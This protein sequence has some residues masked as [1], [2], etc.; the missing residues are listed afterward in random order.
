MPKSLN[1]RA[2]LPRIQ[3]VD[4]KEAEAAWENASQLLAALNGARLGAWYWDIERG[5]INWSRGT[6]A[7][8]GFD[9]NERLAADI[10]YLDLLPEED[11]GRTVLAFEA[12]LRGEP[13]DHPMR[14]RIRW[15]DGSLHW[16]EISGSLVT[17][18]DGR[19]H[20]VGVVREITLQRERETAL[21]ASEQRFAT[22]F[23]L[24]PNVV[25]VTRRNDGM[26]YEV[27]HHFE[28]VLGWPVAQAVNRTTEELELWAD[29][30]R[31]LEWVQA[32]LANN[33]PV[34]REVRLRTAAGH[35]REG[36]LCSQNI[37]LDGYPFLLSTFVDTTERLHAEQLLKDS[38]ERLDLAIESARLGTWD[39]HLPSGMLYASPRAAALHNLPEQ[40]LHVPFRAFFRRLARK[41]R[42]ALIEHFREVLSG[43][44]LHYQA[45][46]CVQLNDGSHRYLETRARLYRDGQGIPTR[47]AGTLI[48]ISDQVEREHRL[49]NSE[50][51]FI[52]LFQASPYPVCVSEQA[53]GRFV[54]VNSSFCETFGWTAREVIGRTAEELELWSDD[55]QR[56]ALQDQLKRFGRVR[57][58]EVI[59]RRK[60]GEPLILEITL[61]PIALEQGPCLLMTA[62]DMS[63]LK[64]AQAQIQHLA[65]HD[66]LTNL[67]NRALLMERISQQVTLLKRHNQRGALL[68][69]DLDHFKHIN[70]SL[71]HPVGD[72]V[73]KVITARLEASVRLE[74]TVAR[75]GG[76]EF[77]ILIGGLEGSR[78]EVTE[79]VRALADT[80]R[81]L[82]AE[83]MSLDGHRLRVTPSIGMALIPDHGTTPADLLKRADIALY[84]A[85]D[86][87]RNT[88]QMFHSAMQK[89]ASERLRMENDLRLAIARGEL[90]LYFQPQLDARA[91]RI[92]GAE[93]LLRWLH[94]QLGQQSPAQF[95]QVLEESG[96]I[97]DVGNWIL[98]Q[99]CGACAR[100]LQ[101]GLIDVDGF[102]LCVN[103][104]PRQFRQADFVDRIERSLRDNQLPCSLLKLE[105]TEGIVIQNLDDTINKMRALKRMGVTFAMDDF[106]TGYSSL[107]YLKRL[108]VDTLKIDQSFVRDCTHD[109]NDAEII[110]AIVAMA[111]SLNLTVIAEGVELSE[112]LEFLDRL[113]CHLYQGY[114][115]SRAVPFEEFQAML[116]GV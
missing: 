57:H 59:G 10:D 25:M 3:A 14:H 95:I 74:D 29:P 48:D 42:E 79:E 26:I 7:L 46:Y 56:D 9:P 33:E 89:V 99:A 104:S 107:T 112:Q 32:T 22:L 19:P 52:R 101:A 38:Q 30:P 4:P 44:S 86:S 11:R 115:Y 62:R 114:L 12:V 40:A 100:L 21:M 102:S 65:Y 76:D 70:D 1:P 5:L 84:R 41:E 110:R 113:G 91:E 54:E 43:A 109:P 105:I 18:R 111:R 39:W 108:P 17:G 63:Q 27:N 15:P 83:P 116:I 93:V 8:F 67:P 53:S 34:T 92:I 13:Q 20:M 73:L 51:K 88:A 49:Q 94:P 55:H 64:N 96:M 66:P 82:L 75:L 80:L 68:F 77:V 72:T 2:R 58:R 35:L 24:S 31:R 23:H 103:I 36:I 37:E 85:K 87:G 90:H 81:E 69:L 71:G 61:E 106:G 47:M 45:T 60:T 28:K 6:Q 97:L 16:I 50:D 78:S 98:D